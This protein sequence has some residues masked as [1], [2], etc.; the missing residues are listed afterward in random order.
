MSLNVPCVRQLSRHAD[1]RV[2]RCRSRV[3][4]GKSDRHGASGR[5]HAK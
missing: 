1:S 3:I 5:H 2:A 4:S